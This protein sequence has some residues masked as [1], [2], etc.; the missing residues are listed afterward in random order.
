[1]MALFEKFENN[2]SWCNSFWGGGAKGQVKQCWLLKKDSASGNN[3]K[4]FLPIRSEPEAKSRRFNCYMKLWTCWSQDRKESSDNHEYMYKSTWQCA[5]VQHSEVII[6]DY[7][8]AENKEPLRGQL[9][10]PTCR[11]EIRSK[12]MDA[13]RRLCA[14]ITLHLEGWTQH[15]ATV[16]F[17]Y[18]LRV[19]FALLWNL[20]FLT[21]L[22]SF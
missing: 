2:E 7:Y 6:R 21:T 5:V 10:T 8:F 12:L 13:C 1:M 17:A 11:W 18:V 9:Q 16:F 22:R 15:E 19:E 4:M 14:H 20:I 3:D